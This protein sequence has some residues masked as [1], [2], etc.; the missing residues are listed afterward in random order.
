MVGIP[1]ARMS[2]WVVC[3]VFSLTAF[4]INWFWSNAYTQENVYIINDNIDKKPDYFKE[5]IN[6]LTLALVLMIY[7]VFYILADVTSDKFKNYANLYIL[8]FIHGCV[9]T[10][11]LMISG[12]SSPLKVLQF[13][14]FSADNF[15]PS[16][17]YMV[18]TALILNWIV[19]R[20]I[21]EPKKSKIAELKELNDKSKKPDEKTVKKLSKFKL[22]PP[23]DENSEF[24][25]FG[26]KSSH[27]EGD[28][29][30]IITGSILLGLGFG[31]SGL[32]IANAVINMASFSLGI[33][34]YSTG[35]VIAVL[36]LHVLGF[37]D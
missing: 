1:Y 34:S 19:N 4:F 8:P 25:E 23:Y 18:G 12:A 22:R 14:S 31:A 24:E 16:F 20:N 9:F 7:G 15:D 30:L 13:I 11:G 27:R 21:I 6:S 36:V 3:V 35:M 2:S 37:R 29:W 28:G 5:V 17:G 10:L 26:R 33:L 32:S